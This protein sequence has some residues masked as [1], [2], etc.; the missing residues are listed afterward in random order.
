[1]AE[2]NNNLEI[3]S[4]LLVN[5]N[6][7]EM[8]SRSYLAVVLSVILPGLGQ[9]YLGQY[10]KAIVIFL[11]FASAIGLFYLNSFPVKEWS[12][13]WEFRSV[14]QDANTTNSDTE[15]GSNSGVS[16]HLWTLDSGK[17]L[18]FRPSWKLK[19]TSSIQGLLCWI[20]AVYGGWKGRPKFV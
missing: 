15:N 12:D 20:Y 10:L 13:L 2:S 19:I 6:P 7:K 1:M 14:A 18:M 9:L 11:V 4:E 17:E 8:H 16:I 3:D 5:R